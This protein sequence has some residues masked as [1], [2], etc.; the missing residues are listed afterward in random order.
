MLVRQLREERVLMLRCP[1]LVVRDKLMLL[2]TPFL[3]QWTFSRKQEQVF[4]GLL[5]SVGASS[6]SVAMKLMASPLRIHSTPA[7]A[8]AD[9]GRP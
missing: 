9:H 3:R 4:A 6:S 2:M 1:S 5:P 8:H 7:S